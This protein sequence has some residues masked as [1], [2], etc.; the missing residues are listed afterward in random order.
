MPKNR[1]KN[2]TDNEVQ[3]LQLFLFK[4]FSCYE[5]KYT[6][7]SLNALRTDPSRP[8]IARNEH[9]IIPPYYII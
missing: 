2:N 5:E 1:R 4:A 8:G 3:R 6:F 7:V 9:L